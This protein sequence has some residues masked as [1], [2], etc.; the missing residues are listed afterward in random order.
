MIR[1]IYLVLKMFIKL[2]LV[3]LNHIRKQWTCKHEH[4]YPAGKVLNTY[5]MYC[6]D[7]SKSWYIKDK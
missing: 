5:D 4:A 7:C 1:Q 6:P 2:N 3:H